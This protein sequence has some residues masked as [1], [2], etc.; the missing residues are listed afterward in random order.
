M[1]SS[2]SAWIERFAAAL[3]VPAPSSDDVDALLE[4]ASIAAHASERVAAPITCWLVA[5]SGRSLAEALRI[6]DAVA[7][8]LLG[9]ESA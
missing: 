3:E 7:E 2:G 6:A 9:I 8:E 1:P 4:L 5:S